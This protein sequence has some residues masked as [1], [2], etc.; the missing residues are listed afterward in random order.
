MKRTPKF[1]FFVVALLILGLAYTSFFGVY[2]TYGDRTDTVIRGASDI[3]FG[4][5][6]RG[7]VDVT[8]GPADASIE[9]D[10]AN[11]NAIKAIIEQ[12]LVGKNITDYEC[13]AD[14]ANEQVIVRF[15]WASDEA[16]YDAT[17]A[18]N[19]LGET[20]LLAFH[21]GSETKEEKVE[22]KDENGE[23]LKDE[24]GNILYDTVTK[25]AG[26][27][28]LTGE[29]VAKA[30]ASWQPD[31]NG[32]TQPVVL[33][34]LQGDAIKAFAD[35]TAKQA[36][37][38][39]ISIWLD[40]Q[41]LSDPQVND[42]IT[43]G[44]AVIT[45]GNSDYSYAQELAN[46]INAG[47]LPFE[48]EAKSFAT[49][50]PTLGEKALDAMVLAALIGF[51]LVAVYIILWY[52]LPGFVAVIAL[53]GQMAA[54]IACISGYFSVFDSFTLTLPG[55]AGIILSIGVG[56]DANVITSERVREEIRR[57]RT[58][59]GAI[60]AGSK[61]SFWA[62][63]D[64]NITVLIVSIVLMGVFGPPSGFWATILSPILRWFPTS[65]TGMVYSF[66]YTLF[67]GVVLNFIM[68]VALSRLMLRSVS[69]LK[70]CRNPWLYGGERA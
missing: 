44:E 35:A 46:K 49:L 42:P 30:T 69:R 41:L 24:D 63:F 38:G 33:L 56:V 50:A 15:P 2:K 9:A 55:I 64:G 10:E 19:E 66:G 53:I 25:P 61:N 22:R 3:R 4:I 52:R 23:V 57:G 5:D 21:I 29:G 47:A 68:G 54:T 70:I 20:A 27:L 36:D 39:T 13:Y 45:L 34:E 37:K 11:I 12:R 1:V 67:I 14:V 18:I 43:T 58:I 48:I 16:D 17:A 7:G 26:E 32:N 65:T 59:D 40:D 8:F 62:I 28:V 31:E 51:A 60:S 6:I